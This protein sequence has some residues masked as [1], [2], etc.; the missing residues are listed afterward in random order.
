MMPAANKPAPKKKKPAK[1]KPKAK[2][3]TTVRRDMQPEDRGQGY[4]TR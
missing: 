3:S 1:A 4:K 2:P